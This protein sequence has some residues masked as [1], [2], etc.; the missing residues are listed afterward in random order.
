[1]S[2]SCVG[3]RLWEWGLG[4]ECLAFC[5]FWSTLISSEC[6]K[7]F[8]S[9]VVSP[10][11]AFSSGPWR[12]PFVQG[13]LPLLAHWCAHRQ[14]YTIT[15]VRENPPMLSHN[16]LCW[17]RQVVGLADSCIGLSFCLNMSASVLLCREHSLLC[18][19]SGKFV[20]NSLFSDS[21]AYLEAL[22]P[23]NQSFFSEKDQEEGP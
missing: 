11:P 2:Q 7:I 22:L 18:G 14:L 10:H 15:G 3:W 6:L 12:H 20:R 17:R 19:I 9:A 1:M 16:I 4:K 13:E 8:A 21:W 5:F 23:P